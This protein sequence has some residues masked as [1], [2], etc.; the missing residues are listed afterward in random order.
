MKF[1]KYHALGNDYIVIDPKNIDHT[2]SDDEIKLICDRHFGVGSDGILYGPLESKSSDFSLRIFNPDASEAEKSGNGLRIFSRYLWDSGSIANAPFS[3]ETKGGVVRSTV[4]D[5][6]LAVSVDMGVI[7]FTHDVLR[8]NIAPHNKGVSALAE[9]IH[10][11]EQLFS[12]YRLSIGNP[13]FVIPIEEL[14]A[15]LAKSVGPV[16]ENDS[17]F[18]NRCN[19]QFM[20]VIDRNTIQIEIWERGAGYT[21]ASGSSSAAAAALAYE[22]DYCDST[23]SVQMPGGVIEIALH[24]DVQGRDIRAVMTGP[25][26]KIFEGTIAD[27]VFA[28]ARD[29]NNDKKNG[30]QR[31][32][33]SVSQ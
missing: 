13:H 27:E 3:I 24:R 11:G 7:A 25:V 26:A 33:F 2:I 8:D 5:G 21:M 15:S 20:K 22:L 12:G 9:T 29:K 28:S 23:I 16:I 31:S 30:W 4:H 32:R 17:R 10:V 14:S 18:T 1:C 6:G 19:I